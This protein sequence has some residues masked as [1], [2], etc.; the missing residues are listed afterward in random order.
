MTVSPA[1]TAWRQY[2]QLRRRRDTT[3]AW[4]LLQKQLPAQ[5]E[6]AGAEREQQRQ[7]M[8][9]Y[10]IEAIP[11]LGFKAVRE[12][13]TEQ[14]RRHGL[15][16]SGISLEQLMEQCRLGVELPVALAAQL[17]LLVQAGDAAPPALLV[18]LAE[19]LALLEHRPAALELID[20]LLRLP[21][22]PGE[23]RARGHGLAALLHYRRGDRS[24]CLE[25]LFAAVAHGSRD[26]IT[27]QFL[28][29]LQCETGALDAA[30]ASLAAIQEQAITELELR[31]R[32]LA[33]G[34]Q[35]AQGLAEP[36]LLAQIVAAL[37]GGH[38]DDGA[39]L[40][41]AAPALLQTAAEALALRDALLRQ[42]LRQGLANTTP[43][44]ELPPARAGSGLQRLGL[45]APAFGPHSPGG[46]ALALS[47]W[48]SAEGVE[49]VVLRT[50]VEPTPVATERW[51]GPV[52]EL[53]GLARTAGRAA[54]RAQELDAVIDLAGWQD[55][56]RQD[57]LQTRLAPLQLGWFNSSFS[58]GLPQLDYLLVDRFQEP[59]QREAFSEGFLVLPGSF[60][61]LAEPLPAPPLQPA[62]GGCLAV[63]APAR[64]LQRASVQLWATILREHPRTDLVFCHPDYGQEVVWQRLLKEFKA[65]GIGAGRLRRQ[66]QPETDIATAAVLDPWPWGHWLSALAAL[67]LGVPVLGRRGPLLH[68]RRTAGVL[69]LLGLGAFAADDGPSYRAIATSL[70]ADSGLQ[71]QLH[72]VI[73][74]Q[75]ASSLLA[76]PAQFA[77]ELKASLN[78]LLN[79]P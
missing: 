62:V 6:P 29:R 66:P 36:Q 39:E 3:A 53:A 22:L 34:L 15:P 78:G 54:V 63:L 75:L 60:L 55:G 21:R 12:L 1:S 69:E 47:P 73:P 56:Q 11:R 27:L 77:A 52:V 59:E 31:E 4:D 26:P 33:Y 70:L 49:V 2:W 37:G 18:E 57:L 68:Q 38:L 41:A 16:D 19:T 46:L 64:H 10:V 25:Q 67:Q 17:Q 7:L 23:L 35:L 32:R 48:L 58:T 61:A 30:A 72:G 50:L 76:K 44:A 79:T 42:R 13:L 9:A 45:L 74:Q 71:E 20:E 65:E 5:L 8:D 24:Q 51:Q 28:C 14:Q 43:A 40:L